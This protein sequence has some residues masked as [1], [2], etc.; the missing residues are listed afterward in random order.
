MLRQR[1]TF[2][3]SLGV[4]VCGAAL[5]A[6]QSPSTPVP[7]EQ[8]DRGSATV[9]LLADI[10]P[11]GSSGATGFTA[12]GRFVY[13]AADDGTHG[14]ELWRTDGTREGTTLV[15]DINPGAGHAA[16][17]EITI[18]RGRMFLAATSADFGR[19]LWS[20]DGTEAGTTLVH[21]INPGPADSQPA[22]F[23]EFRGALF[24]RAQ[25][26][27]GLEL[28]RTGGTAESTE[29]VADL[30]PGE[31]GSVPTY[32]TVFRNALFFSADDL[33]TPGIGFDRELWRTDGTGRGTVRVRDINPGP[34]PSIPGELTRLGRYLVFK[35]GDPEL[36]GELW[37]T[38]GTEAGTVP[39]ADMNPGP[40]SSFP[41]NLVRVGR[42]I[43]FAADDGRTGRELWRTDGTT[44]GTALV[45][46]INPGGESS[47]PEGIPFR[48][49]YLFIAGDAAHGRELW[50][51]D[52]TTAGTRLVRDINPGPEGSG[53]IGFVA[54]GS[55]AFFSIIRQSAAGDGT[56]H[57]ELWRTDGTEAGTQRVW[58]A[59][60]RSSGY[61]IEGLTRIGPLLFFTAP[62]R[63]DAEGMSTDFEPHVLFLGGLLF[64]DLLDSASSDGQATGAASMR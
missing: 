53:P 31:Q 36:G 30:H 4:A 23:T 43:F 38:D 44:E 16:P 15:R 17:L 22:L 12:F 28:W 27:A 25:D 14:A 45:A 41:T 5:L 19:E 40:A 49:G 46:D 51:S 26:A 32:P 34:A 11:T 54:A 58:E 56:V 1:F 7:A 13:F 21:D 59:P 6:Q 8:R 2:T 60:G 62:T 61:S 9:H 35:A 50:F 10:N 48:N 52:G 42:T 33:Y 18:Y 29:R 37:R 55:M 20:S 63:V 3:T 57:T 24:F 39:V 64:D 47:G